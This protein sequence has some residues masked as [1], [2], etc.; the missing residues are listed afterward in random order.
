MYRYNQHTYN[1]KRVKPPQLNLKL[2]VNLKVNVSTRN[3]QK[4]LLSQTSLQRSFI[5]VHFLQK[6]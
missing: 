6:T 3:V 1:L 4:N 2:L 5:L